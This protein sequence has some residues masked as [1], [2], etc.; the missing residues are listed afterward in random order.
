[1]TRITIMIERRDRSHWRFKF[2]EENGP[3]IAY[4]S[5]WPV[6]GQAETYVEFPGQ[7]FALGPF[8]ITA[9][10]PRRWQRWLAWLRGLRWWPR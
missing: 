5:T 8:S 3:L 4:C 7:E 1:M 9:G 2:K 6:G 10:Q